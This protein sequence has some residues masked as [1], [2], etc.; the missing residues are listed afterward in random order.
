[1]VALHGGILA[2]E[3]DDIDASNAK[4]F[5]HDFPIFPRLER[6]HTLL[7]KFMNTRSSS[8][9]TSHIASLITKSKDH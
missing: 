9:S 1:M 3:Y 7:N 6:L 2:K 4:V 8:G 5:P